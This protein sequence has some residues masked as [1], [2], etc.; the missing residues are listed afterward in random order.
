MGIE[1][2]QGAAYALGETDPR[3]EFRHEAPDFRVVE[4]GAD[5]LVAQEPGSP[6]GDDPGY[7]LRRHVDELG[8]QAQDPADDE[9]DGVPGED[10][11]RSHVEG[12]GE[13]R[14]VAEQP[15]ETYREIRGV[16]E[17]PEGLPVSRDD[18]VPAFLHPP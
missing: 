16:G 9:V 17:G 5:G 12:F 11:V 1:P 8:A 6:L 15:D 4:D 18:D 2:G 13:G 14:R 3:P 7:V 10:L